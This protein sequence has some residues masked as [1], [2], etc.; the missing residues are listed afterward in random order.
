MNTALRYAQLV[1][2]V[3]ETGDHPLT[4]IFL[5]QALHIQPNDKAIVYNIAMVQQKAAEMLFAISPAKRSLGDLQRAID[6]AA[7]AQK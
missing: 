2:Q 4:S 5:N 3:V 6:Q 1:R 7:H